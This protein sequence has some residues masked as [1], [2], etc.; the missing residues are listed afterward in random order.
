MNA[1][2]GRERKPLLLSLPLL[3][4]LLPFPA[5]GATTRYVDVATSASGDGLSWQTAKKT[6]QEAVDA[7]PPGDEIWVAEGVYSEQVILRADLSLYGGFSKAEAE[8]GE[9]DLV[10]HTS[11]IVGVGGRGNF[12]LTI[13]DASVVFDGFTLERAFLGL[14]ISPSAKHSSIRNCRFMRNERGAYIEGSSCDIENCTFIE[15]SGY[16]GSGL[17]A[18]QMAGLNIRNCIF[19]DN[20]CTGTRGTVLLDGC[21]DALVSASTIRD[22]V[23]RTVGSGDCYGGGICIWYSDAILEGCVISGNIAESIWNPVFHGFGGGIYCYRGEYPTGDAL[24][25][26][27]IVNNRADNGGGLGCRGGSYEQPIPIIT[28]CTFAGNMAAQ[29][30][31][32]IYCE[33]R[34]SYTGWPPQPI[35]HASYASATNCIFRQN[36]PSGVTMLGISW[37]RLINNLFYGNGYAVQAGLDNYVTAA[38]VNAY[39]WGW[40]NLDGDPAFVNAAAGN[41]HLL[42][43][44]LTISF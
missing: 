10:H 9:R 7:A 16:E 38:E 40:G 22:N 12:L 6:I 28:N 43:S 39:L 25:N 35:P 17:C 11:A 26:C 36:P 32:G 44:T 4:L 33:N 24:A 37:V 23:L 14:Y 15:N 29:S 20:V 34:I 19:E 41:Y 13:V 31:G 21:P 18:H 5:S 8:V 1:S 27:L 3:C 30:G 42:P 2:R